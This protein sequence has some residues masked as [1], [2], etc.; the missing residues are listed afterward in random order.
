MQAG[1]GVHEHQMQ[2]AIA[3]VAMRRQAACAHITP[4]AGHHRHDAFE[5]TLHISRVLSGHSHPVNATALDTLRGPSADIQ[6]SIQQFVAQ[7]DS[8]ALM[9][10]YQE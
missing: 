3:Q 8:S 6:A 5:A 9:A 2:A 10:P 7:R 4:A 1:C